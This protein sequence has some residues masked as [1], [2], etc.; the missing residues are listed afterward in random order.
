MNKY[1]KSKPKILSVNV[2]L[3]KEINFGGKKVTTAIFKEP[4]KGHV[5]LRM[6]NLDGARQADLTVH[7]GGDKAVHSYPIE[8]YEYWRNIFPAIEMPNEMFSENFTS[9]DLIETQVT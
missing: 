9:K 4:V 7:G 3:P 1:R 8:H 6:D 2:S 5:M